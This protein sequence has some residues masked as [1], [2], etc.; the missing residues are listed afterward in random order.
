MAELMLEVVAKATYQEWIRGAECVYEKWENLPES[1]RLRLV[2][3]AR[4]G[5][6]ALANASLPE[7]MYADSGFIN[8]GGKAVR[9]LFSTTLRAIAAES[10]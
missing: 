1:Y 7:R 4:A 9:N 5:I 2:D 10:N 3:S 8:T 6:N